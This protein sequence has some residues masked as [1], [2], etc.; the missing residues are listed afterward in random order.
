MNG[1][2]SGTQSRSRAWVGVLSIIGLMFAATVLLTAQ[3][4]VVDVEMG[5]D[6]FLCVATATAIYGLVAQPLVRQTFGPLSTIEFQAR[7]A[8]IADD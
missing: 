6:G 2:N 1:K 7:D 3:S 4:G 5:R 8:G